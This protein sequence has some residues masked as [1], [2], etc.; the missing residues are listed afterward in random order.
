M[1]SAIVVA[2]GGVGDLVRITPLVSVCHAL[3]YETDVLVACDFDG[4]DDLVRG[5]RAV[6]RVFRDRSAWTGRGVVDLAGIETA[7][8]V[9]VSGTLA[10]GRRH[11]FRA[12]R[13]LQ[14]D[15]ARWLRDGDAACVEAVARQLGWQEPL[16]PP[17][18]VPSSRSF[19]LPAG[20]IALHPGC[21]ANWPWKKWHGFDALAARLESVVIIGTDA[22]L[23]NRHTY[24]ARP[25]AWPAHARSF[26]GALTLADTAALLSECEALVSNDSGLM[27][28]AAALGIPTFGVFGITS[29]A[30]EAMPVANMVPVSKGLP[31][32]PACRRGP[33]GRRDCE[34]HLE[35]LRTL[36]A[37]DV[38]GRMRRVLPERLWTTSS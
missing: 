4:G 32:E 13:H 33:W 1:P 14:F 24:F 2:A 18:V 35:C 25:F 27:H 29:P 23:E 20:T 11:P 34:F 12:A 5:A 36:T 7:Y 3:G 19:G 31:C 6:R 26:V 8:D 9:A 10:G 22:D 15:R 38:I 17:F 28:V 21:K 16:P 37:D 30:R